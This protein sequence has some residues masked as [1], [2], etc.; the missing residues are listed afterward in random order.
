MPKIDDPAWAIFCAFLDHHRCAGI[1]G[2]SERARLALAD[3]VAR[4]FDPP[5]ALRAWASILTAAADKMDAPR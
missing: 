2:A 1:G 4:A 5:A 3:S